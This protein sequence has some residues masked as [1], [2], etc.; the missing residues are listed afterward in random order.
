M[1]DEKRLFLRSFRV[2]RLPIRRRNLQDL[3]VLRMVEGI[4][5]SDDLDKYLLSGRSSVATW[6]LIV[7]LYTRKRLSFSSDVSHAFAGIAER[8]EDITNSKLEYGIPLTS[9]PHALLWV[10][11]GS[12][13]KRRECHFP[14]PRWS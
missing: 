1:T 9:L 14:I 8:L 2:Q 11:I 12:T 3:P 4:M 7:V 10:H 13:G 6:A 5:F